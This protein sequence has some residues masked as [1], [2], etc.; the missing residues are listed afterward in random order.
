VVGTQRPEGKGTQFTLA[1]D[2]AFGESSWVWASLSGGTGADFVPVFRGDVDLNLGISGPWSMGLE[3]AWNRFRDGSS[4]ALLQ[5]GPAWLGETWSASTRIQQLRY[6]PGQDS[7]TGYIA[8]VRW[9]TNN[10]LRWHSLRVAWGRGIIDSLQPDG[11]PSTGT[12]FGGGGRG[13]GAGSGI[14][15]TGTLVPSGTLAPKLNEFL[16][17]T[18]SHFPLTKQWAIRADVAWGQRE[19]QFNMWS[20]SFQTLFTF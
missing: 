10:L 7:D 15:T 17:S 12:S 20:V 1:K 8:D 14:T 5:A 2:H 3:G 9:G 16:I 4:T 18:S 13:H 6:L 19:S 11:S